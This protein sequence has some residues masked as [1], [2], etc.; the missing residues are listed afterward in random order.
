MR[1]LLIEKIK[2]EY[3]DFIAYLETLSNIDVVVKCREKILKEE[4]SRTVQEWT[5]ELSDFEIETL[6]NMKNSL[7]YLYWNVMRAQYFDYETLYEI[8]KNTLYDTN[9]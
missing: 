1:D 6:Y 2:K 7:D 4:I 8:I 5:Y 9:N 3:S